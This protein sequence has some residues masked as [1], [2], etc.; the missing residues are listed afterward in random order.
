MESCSIYFWCLS[1]FIQNTMCCHIGECINNLFFCH[2][3]IILEFVTIY[4]L[5]CWY[6]HLGS[7]L[8]LLL[9]AQFFRRICVCLPWIHTLQW[10]LGSVRVGIACLPQIDLF[11][12]LSLIWTLYTTKPLLQQD[13][14]HAGVVTMFGSAGLGKKIGREVT[15]S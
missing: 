9:Q 5:Y 6:A 14:D 12:F 1:S 7:V 10:T 4:L 2:C 11:I 3:V 13:L 8:F 15:R